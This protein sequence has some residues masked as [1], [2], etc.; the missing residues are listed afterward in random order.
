MIKK[1]LFI[2]ALALLALAGC[3][4]EPVSLTVM[5]HDSFAISE[6]V[7]AEFEQANNV[8]VN[9]LLSGDAGSLVN[10]AILSKAN[11][12]ADVLYGVD[13]TFLTREIGRAHV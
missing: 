1:Y 11:P 5:T 2:V 13:N 6:G 4:P 7:I 8:N 10:R 9:F 3:K 12:V